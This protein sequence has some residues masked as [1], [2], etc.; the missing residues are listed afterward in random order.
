MSAVNY[1]KIM[2]KFIFALL[3]IGLFFGHISTT[4]AQLDMPSF[5][6]FSSDERQS[7]QTGDD[8]EIQFKAH[9]FSPSNQQ[10]ITMRLA[11]RNTWKRIRI[12]YITQSKDDGVYIFNWIIPEN[13]FERHGF[14]N[15][16]YF[17][18]ILRANMDGKLVRKISTKSLLYIQKPASAGPTSTL[19]TTATVTDEDEETEL[20]DPEKIIPANAKFASRYTFNATLEPW[21]IRRLTV[22]N[23]TEDDGFES[24]VNES[25]NVIETVYLRYPN[26]AGQTVEKSVAFTSY[27]A[28][29]AGLDFYIPKHG[30]A[31]VEI[32]I[33]LANTNQFSGETFRVG[34][35][36]TGNTVSTF[37]AVSQITSTTDNVM[38][39]TLLANN[40]EEFVVRSG[41]PEFELTMPIENTL[42]NGSLD[43]YKF[44]FFASSDVGLGRLVFDVSQT[45]LTQV[46]QIQIFRN[47]QLLDPSD[48]S[49]VRNVY[50][51]WDAGG[52][53][54]FAHTQQNGAGTGMDCNG[55]T[56]QSSKLIVTFTEEE[57]VPN[58]GVNSYTLRFNVMGVNDGDQFVIRLD[59][60]DEQSQLNIGGAISNTG[61]IY[62]NGLGNEIFSN[63]TDFVSE[64]TTLTDRNIIWTD[65]S[66][67]LHKYTTFTPAVSPTVSGSSTA[68]FTNGYLLKIYSLEPVLWYK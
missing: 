66:A 52:T 46:D 12:G 8:V 47:G 25:S 57:K 44:D 67:D 35:Q 41:V 54:C 22:V 32:W 53:S 68:D 15:D 56:T 14:D 20:P 9:G 16:S 18:I 64:A 27:K 24:D 55:G 4:S 65:R 26:E 10:G 48:Q 62:N 30:S 63:S 45:G 61:K 36:E 37:E 29:L 13:F 50:L 39:F 2:K 19:K 21:V 11:E 49:V 38:N 6:I 33:G 51:M 23:D 1:D 3:A 40:V 59:T 34:L 58:T 42:T 28:T 31:D 5:E 17:K 7:Y 60:G 43:A